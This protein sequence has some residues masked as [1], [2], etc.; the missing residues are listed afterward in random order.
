M[1]YQRYCGPSVIDRN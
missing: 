1:G